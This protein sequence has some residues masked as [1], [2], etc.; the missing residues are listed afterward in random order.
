M[1]RNYVDHHY[2]DN[3]MLCCLWQ[4]FTL[5][6]YS[7]LCTQQNNNNI[8]RTKYNHDLPQGIVSWNRGR[9]KSYG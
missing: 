5:L 1:Y 4:G 3:L 6:G 8:E 9:A 2:V 7:E